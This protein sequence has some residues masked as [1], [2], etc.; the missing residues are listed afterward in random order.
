MLELSYFANKHNQTFNSTS[1][2][3]SRLSNLV[4]ISQKLCFHKRSLTTNTPLISPIMHYV[5]F[6]LRPWKKWEPQ[7]RAVTRL[8]TG[9]HR[10]GVWFSAREE[11]FLFTATSRLALR[12]TEGYFPGVTW[13]GSQD[14]HSRPSRIQVENAWRYTSTTPF[15]IIS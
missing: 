4:I 13:P 12:S 8:R 6:Y 10:I 9:H 5:T 14:G 3:A 1:K 11:H 2:Q 15:I 7:F